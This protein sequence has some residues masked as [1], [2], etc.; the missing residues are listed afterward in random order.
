[1]AGAT[2]AP[3]A[4]RYSTAYVNFEL[5]RYPFV[6]HPLTATSPAQVESACYNVF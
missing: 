2:P 1:M 6:R 5:K 4:I 3:V